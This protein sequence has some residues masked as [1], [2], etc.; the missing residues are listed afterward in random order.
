LVSP[1]FGPSAPTTTGT[2]APVDDFGFVDLEA[3]VIVG[4]EAGCVPDRAVDVEHEAAAPTD[5]VMMV[6]AHPIFVPG[7]RT[8]RLD[9]TNQILLNEGT[10]CVV[11]RLPRDRS[12]PGPNIFDEILGRCVWAS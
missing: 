6:I 10:E 4:C 12:D 7:D 11:D 3:M 8:R 9:P 1:G 2:T 5:E